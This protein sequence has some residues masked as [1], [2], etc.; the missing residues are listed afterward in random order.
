MQRAHGNQF[1]KAG[2]AIQS[3]FPRGH[4]IGTLRA[5]GLQRQ[6]QGCHSQLLAC[7][8]AIS[9]DSLII[10]NNIILCLFF[11]VSHLAQHWHNFSFTSG[12]KIHPSL[13]SLGN[14]N[15]MSNTAHRLPATPPCYSALLLIGEQITP[16]L[17]W[18]E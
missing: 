3:S 2:T 6:H 4:P 8:S 14:F 7:T 12:E 16:V 18:C 15:F 17:S 5:L 11:C 9:Q 10:I 1:P 13:S